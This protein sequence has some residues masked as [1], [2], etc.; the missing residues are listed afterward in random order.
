MRLKPFGKGRRK[1]NDQPLLVS[2]I[3]V[4]RESQR[5][6]HIE[7]KEGFTTLAHERI[8]IF[9]LS[10]HAGGAGLSI[11]ACTRMDR[12]PAVKGNLCYSHIVKNTHIIVVFPC[13][14]SISIVSPSTVFLLHSNQAEKMG[15]CLLVLFIPLQG[16][17][18]GLISLMTMAPLSSPS[19]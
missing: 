10:E 7:R 18:T 12:Q 9:S 5:Q 4:K 2:S 6:T 1:R 8:T 17:K 16:D 3:V 13:L 19:S 15:M 11:V 14:S